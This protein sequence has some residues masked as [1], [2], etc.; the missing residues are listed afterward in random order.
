[1]IRDMARSGRCWADAGLM[2]GGRCWGEAGPVMGVF[3]MFVWNEKRVVEVHFNYVF[4]YV[5]VGCTES[6][7]NILIM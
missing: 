7:K 2:L 1:M 5:G 4:S 3:E 6:C